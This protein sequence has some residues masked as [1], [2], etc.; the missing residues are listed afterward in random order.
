MNYSFEYFFIF[1]AIV[2][3][4]EGFY[5]QWKINIHDSMSLPGIAEKLAY[6]NFDE[7]CAPICS[8]GGIF[9]KYN[10]G[11]LLQKKLKQIFILII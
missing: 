8:F 11:N 3:Y 10:E 6:M 2:Y 1:E 7:T 4:A 9:K 5:D